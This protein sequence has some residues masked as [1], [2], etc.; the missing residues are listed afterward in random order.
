MFERNRV[1]SGLQPTAVPAEITLVD[2]L[3]LKGKFLISAARTLQDVLNGEATFLEFEPYGGSR[4]FVAKT[5]LQSVKLVN[6]AAPA[7]LKSRA[8]E[9]Q[10]FD[11]RKVLGVAADASWEDIRQAYH[12]LAMAYHPDRYANVQLPGEVREYL[13]SM[14]RYVNAAF[15]ALEPVVKVPRHPA[16]ERA[17]AAYTSS[18]R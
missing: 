6:P 11:P 9:V 8:S 16:A 5:A 12:R 2:G 3:V 7:S 14:T 10:T 17:E 4:I 18:A 13:E 15:A 1:D